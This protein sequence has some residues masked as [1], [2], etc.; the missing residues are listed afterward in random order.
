LNPEIIE[1]GFVLVLCRK[2]GVHEIASDAI[3]LPETTI[4]EQ[5]EFV[6]DDEWNYTVGKALLEHQQPS[7]A[8]VAVLERMDLLEMYMEVDD[9]L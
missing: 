8:A 2:T 9:F 1:D 6:C 4:V 3:P 5:F 7:H